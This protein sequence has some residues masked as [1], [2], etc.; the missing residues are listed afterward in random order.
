MSKQKQD[1]GKGIRALLENMDQE[2]GADFVQKKKAEMSHSSTIPLEAIEINPFQPRVEFQEEALSDLADSIRVHG[3]IQPVTVRRLE[4]GRF[5]L[6]SGERRLRASKLA[7]LKEIPAFVR[8]ANDQEMLEIALIENIQREDLNAIEISI[9]F[10]RLLDEC[11]LTHEQL[12]GRLGKNRTTV[13]NF[14]RLLK[15]PPDIQTGLRDKSISMGHAR[16]ILSLE[17][18]VAQLDV[19]REVIKQGMSVR[20]VEAFIKQY[21]QGGKKAGGSKPV[22]VPVHVRKV[23]EELSSH[24]STRVVIKQDKSGKGQITISFFSDDDLYRIKDLLD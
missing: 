13:T 23:Q 10:K 19:F 7:G 24:L 4:S 6:I 1:L 15:L 11:N 14:L 12:A 17:D 5:Q 16:A 21:Q 8:D 18:P 2:A 20:E 9:N 22:Q 3:V